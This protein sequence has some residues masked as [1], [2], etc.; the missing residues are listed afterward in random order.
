MGT[1]TVEGIRGRWGRATV[2]AKGDENAMLSMKQIYERIL[3]ERTDLGEE[4]L[5]A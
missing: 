3:T 5:A 1:L 4:E 2:T